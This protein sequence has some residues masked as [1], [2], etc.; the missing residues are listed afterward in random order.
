MAIDEIPC[1]L[2]KITQTIHQTGKLIVVFFWLQKHD[3]GP[4]YICLYPSR[5]YP[6]LPVIIALPETKSIAVENQWLEDEI[7]F[8][9]PA[10]SSGVMF[11]SGGVPKVRI[12]LQ[13]TPK[14]PSTKSH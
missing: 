4:G 3:Q 1:L 12:G 14:H 5:S 6:S 2:S 7:S 9:G 10:L 8:W 11:A 13:K